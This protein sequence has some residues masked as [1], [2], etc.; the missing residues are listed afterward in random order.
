MLWTFLGCHSF[1][2]AVAAVVARFRGF[3]RLLVRF[4]GTQQAIDLSGSNGPEQFARLNF[5]GQGDR[6]ALS[7][8]PDVQAVSWKDL[9]DV[10]FRDG[11]RTVFHAQ[12]PR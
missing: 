6:R 11:Q 5:T 4:A 8:G 7:P 9:Q 10:D 1:Q 12:P 2:H 3:G